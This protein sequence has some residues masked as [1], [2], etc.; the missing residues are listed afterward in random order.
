MIICESSVFTWWCSFGIPRPSCVPGRAGHHD[1]GHLLGIGRG[2]GIQHVE[3]AGPVYVTNAADG[4]DVMR[5]AASAANK[6][7]ARG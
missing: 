1:D 5:A 2:D 4:A 3:R 7:L 6:A